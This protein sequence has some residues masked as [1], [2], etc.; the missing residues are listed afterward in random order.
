M[1]EIPPIQPVES[2]PPIVEAPPAYVRNPTPWLFLFMICFGLIS[3]A[4]WSV[5]ARKADEPS[6]AALE[7][8]LK[9]AMMQEALPNNAFGR[10][11]LSEALKPVKVEAQR[12]AGKSAHAARILLV[13][14]HATRETPSAKALNT[15]RKSEDQEDQNFAKIYSTDKLTRAEAAAL[16][17]KPAQYSE[18]LAEAQAYEK[19]GDRSKRESLLSL[20]EYAPM[21]IAITIMFG[22]FVLGIGA[23]VGLIF[24]SR[25][26]KW[27]FQEIPKPGAQE[28]DRLAVRAGFAFCAYIF[29]QFVALMFVRL[30]MMEVA[31]VAMMVSWFL[32]VVG[33]LA[34]NIFGV[35]ADPFPKIFGKAKPFGHLA[36]LGVSGFLA[37]IP[38][39]VGAVL[40]TMLMSKLFPAPSHPISEDLMKGDPNVLLTSFLLACVAAPIVEETVF[41]GVLLRA[42]LS[43]FKSPWAAILLQAFIFAAIH[44]QG[45]AGI[46]P[47][48]A[49]GA[50]CGWLTWRSGSLLPAMILHCVHNTATLLFAL[51]IN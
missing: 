24:L 42:L 28:G 12:G 14:Q 9:V 3:L 51:S 2:L 39:L 44:P 32:L 41:R 6:Y 26:P 25:S 27:P 38:V 18:R 15:L 34:F 43:L 37:N 30:Q 8:Q 17:P 16:S 40:V 33:I 19:A 10:Q 46:P 48:M 22:F 11:P 45:P 50:M 49:V 21:L 35:E 23:L 5:Y 31:N 1:S 36:T 13:V 20:E 29:A 7:S 47:L 4:I